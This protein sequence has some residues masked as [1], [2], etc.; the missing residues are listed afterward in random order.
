[1]GLI[2]YYALTGE[3]LFSGN[4]VLEILE[5]RKQFERDPESKLKNLEKLPKLNIE[6]QN[7]VDVVRKLLKVNP[8][9]RYSSLHALIRDIHRL[10]HA[11]FEDAVAVQKSYRR[12]LANNRELIRE[13]YS[14]LIADENSRMAK[15]FLRMR[16]EK[17]LMNRQ[18]AMLQMAIDIIINLEDVDYKK[19]FI[20]LFSGS[21]DN[22][23]Q[24]NHHHGL[25]LS[26]YTHFM[27][28]LIETISQSDPEYQKDKNLKDAWEDTK[29]SFLEMLKTHVPDFAKIK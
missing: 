9:E 25:G 20:A 12:A 22:K 17:K 26:D 14:N 1:L 3:E 10:S 15:I 5:D 7:L 4:S 24:N 28:K 6:G 16:N 13:F 21:S 23:N 11:E 29:I 27:I 8:D 2:A 18:Y 19:K